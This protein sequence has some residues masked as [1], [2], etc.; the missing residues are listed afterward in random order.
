MVERRDT[1]DAGSARDLACQPVAVY[2]PGWRG[3]DDVGAEGQLGVDARL[4]IVGRGEDA[5]ID[6][7]GEQ[8]PEHEQA[9]VDRIAPTADAR[10]QEAGRGRSAAGDGARGDPGDESTAQAYEKQRGADPEQERR[11]EHVNREGEGRIRVGVDDGRESCARRQPVDEPGDEKAHQVEVEPLPEGHSFAADAPTGVADAAAEHHPSG[12]DAN[13][14]RG[15][16]GQADADAERHEDA[17][18]ADSAGG[19]GQ[20]DGDERETGPDRARGDCGHDALQYGEQRKVASARSARTQECEALPVALHRAERGQIGEA[21]SDERPGHREHDV[22]R[23][24]VERVAGRGGEVVAEVVDENDLARKR[25]LHPVANPGCLL[26]CAR[27]SARERS[28]VHL[29]LNLPLRSTLRSRDGGGGGPGRDRGKR[30]RDPCSK[31]LERQDR[32]VGGRLSRSRPEQG[33]ERLEELIRCRHDRDATDPHANRC[34]AAARC[35][36]D[37]VARLRLQRR[38]QLLVEYDFAGPERSTEEAKGVEMSE[39]SR[40]YR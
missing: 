35:H 36:P 34:R 17:S 15:S 14:H 19:A 24:G 10:E 25:P 5:E 12:V 11:E 3:C 20:P 8:Q 18:D 22:E 7:E 30:R 13:R 39:V 32:N 23:L 21:E 31:R 6:P 40:G 37:D 38:R 16:S 2:C 26:E 27:R 4:L 28:G 29:R 1:C 33:V 9:A